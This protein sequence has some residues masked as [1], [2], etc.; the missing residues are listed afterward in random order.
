[1]IALIVAAAALLATPQTSSSDLTEFTRL[2][3]VWNDAHKRGDAEVLDT[4]FADDIVIT[5]PEMPRMGKSSTNL[6]RSGRMKFDRYETSD[7][8]VHAYG[9]AAI[10]TGRLKR[11]RVNDGKTFEDDWQFT[12]SYVRRQGAWQVIAFHASATPQR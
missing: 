10:V 4:L 7:V 12:K 11:A 9:D 1:M 3:Q 6:F 5:V 8:N 2:E